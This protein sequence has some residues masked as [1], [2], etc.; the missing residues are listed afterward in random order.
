M[1]FWSLPSK[2][3]YS[4]KITA[5]YAKYAK[6]LQKSTEENEENKGRAR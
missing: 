3:W 4:G 5:K 2:Y 1:N 6:T